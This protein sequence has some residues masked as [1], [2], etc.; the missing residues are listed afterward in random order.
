MR[1]RLRHLLI[2]EVHRAEVFPRG[3]GMAW[4]SWGRDSVT[5]VPIPFN[6]IIGFVRW[7]YFALMHGWARHWNDR[8]RLDECLCAKCGRRLRPLERGP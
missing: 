2:R 6:V 5:C 7:L 1:D 4:Q 3:Y 8:C